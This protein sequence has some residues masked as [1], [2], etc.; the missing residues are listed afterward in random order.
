MK[1]AID[2]YIALLLFERKLTTMPLFQNFTI[3]IITEIT[4]I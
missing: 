1:F 3:G 2:D 4:E